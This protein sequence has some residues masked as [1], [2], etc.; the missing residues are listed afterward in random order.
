MCNIFITMVQYNPPYARWRKYIVFKIMS[1]SDMPSR[2][3]NSFHSFIHQWL[4]SPS[5]GPGLFFS[6]VIFL[7]KT[8]GLLGLRI[9]LS[10]GHYLHTGQ[11]KHR[12]N[13]HTHT[14][15]HALGGI[16][17]HNP[18][19][20]ASKVSSCLTPL[21]HCDRPRTGDTDHNI[22]IIINTFSLFSRSNT[23]LYVTLNWDKTF[24]NMWRKSFWYKNK[25]VHQSSVLKRN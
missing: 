17:A 1:I 12:V 13:T 24:I 19:V 22:Y 16:R 5:L 2:T 11:H 9:S 6:F 23:C 8:I 7:T 25:Y 3:G 15:I 4:Y 10:Q 14:N 18:S 20:W 21:R